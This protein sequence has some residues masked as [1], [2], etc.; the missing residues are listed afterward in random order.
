MNLSWFPE[1]Y[2]PDHFYLEE[3][4][5][6]VEMLVWGVQGLLI[7]MAMEGQRQCDPRSKGIRDSV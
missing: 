5:V 3:F 2:I 6:E 1:F 4:S 7:D